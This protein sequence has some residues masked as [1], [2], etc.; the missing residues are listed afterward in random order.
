MDM[1]RVVA[2]RKSI[3]A[4]LEAEGTKISI[5]DVILKAVAAALRQHPNCNAQWHGDHIRRFNAVHLGVAVAIEDGLITPVVRDA[6]RKGLVRIGAE[7]KEL[8]GRARD[9]RLM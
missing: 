4:V 2:A 5:N 3:N 9:K 1:G 8:A 6:H 7:V